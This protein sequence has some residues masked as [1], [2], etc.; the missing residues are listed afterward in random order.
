M[1]ILHLIIDHQV[2]ER[3]LG[4]FETHFPNSNDVL[5]FSNNSIFKH[6]KSHA[7]CTRVSNDKVKTF[8]KSF[9]FDNYNYIVAHYLTFEMIDFINTAPHNINVCWEI[10]GADLYNQFLTPMGYPLQFTNAQQYESAK[11][12]I[13][14]KL[15]LLKIAQFVLSGSIKQFDFIKIRY[16]KMITKR[17]DSI[18]V[19]CIG[20]AILF[21]KYSGRDIPVFKY[22]NYSLKETLGELY[23]A[24]FREDNRKILIGNSASLSNNHFYVLNYLLN[25]NLDDSEFIIPLSYGGVSK[26]KDD[27]MRRFTETFPN[28]IE[29]IL[30]Y[31]P[32][33]EYNKMFLN[34]NVMI[35][36]S[37]RQESIGTIVMGLYLGIKI[38]M[39]NKSP[40]Y[41]SLINEGFIIFKIEKITE[42]SIKSSLSV[43][44]KEHNRSLLLNLYN[45]DAFAKELKRQFV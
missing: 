33:H 18:A 37:W 4:I 44:V 3:M 40:L 2:I 32:L 22:F 25:L 39:S 38:F 45:E 34:V 6:L 8:A 23:S 29:Y 42:E 14:R 28:Q 5:I 10:Y 26:Y 7:D 35:M 24:P 17:L 21:E 43:E 30:D 1:K 13:L 12:K 15:G 27:V 19:G 36:S 20:D 41:F 16:F 9:D 11:V 31:K